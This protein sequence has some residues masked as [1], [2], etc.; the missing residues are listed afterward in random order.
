MCLYAMNEVFALIKFDKTTEK[1]K[2]PN[3]YGAFNDLLKINPSPEGVIAFYDKII[4]WI[5]KYACNVYF[6]KQ[7]EDV[8]GEFEKLYSEVADDYSYVTFGNSQQTTQETIKRKLKSKKISYI[9]ADFKV[10]RGSYVFSLLDLENNIET[11]RTIMELYSFI[12]GEPLIIPPFAQNGRP[13]LSNKLI[14]SCRGFH[15]LSKFSEEM[16]DSFILESTFQDEIEA[17]TTEHTKFKMFDP[18]KKC[19]AF[20]FYCDNRDD[21]S[22]KNFLQ[23]TRQMIMTPSMIEGYPLNREDKYWEVYYKLASEIICAYLD[24]YCS[25]D[26]YF[27]RTNSLYELSE[28]TGKFKKKSPSTIE[29]EKQKHLWGYIELHSVLAQSILNSKVYRCQ[30]CNRHFISKRNDAKT[31]G[32]YC[33]N[34]INKDM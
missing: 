8:M 29:S 25:P 27:S 21:N 1:D 5:K 32:Y 6:T 15:P 31:C 26:A 2:V 11:L 7:S 18:D 13:L 16:Q 12:Q 10:K 4:R 30:Y 23:R 17:L 28:A 14:M 20:N 33:R 24:T 19:E 22:K 34:H 3:Y 9:D